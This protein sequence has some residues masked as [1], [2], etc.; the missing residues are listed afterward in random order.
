[1]EK[2]DIGQIYTEINEA[3]KS[4]DHEKV[5]SLSDKILKSDP[6]E[7]EA[8][9]TKLTAMT[10]LSR[11]DDIISI[12]EKGNQN[13]EYLLEYA[14]SLHEKKKYSESIAVLQ[15]YY[16][17]RADIKASINELLAQNYYKMGN[18]KESYKTYKEIV[19]AKISS[20]ELEEEKDLISNFLASY[21]LSET[22]DENMLNSMTK[23]LNSWE[24][25]YNYC[26]VCLQGGK[27]NETMETLARMKNEYSQIDDEFN[28]KKLVNLN[29]NLIQKSFEGFDLSKYSNILDE[30]EKFF[31]ENKH[32]ELFPY[33]YNNFIHIKKDK[34]SLNEILR[35]FDNIQ[36]TENLTNEEKNTLILNKIILLLRANRYNEALESYKNLQPSFTD[37]RYVIVYCYIYFKQEKIEKLDELVKND[38][39]LS[40]KPIAHLILIQLMLSTLNA[41]TIENFHFKVLN[42]INKFFEFSANYHFLSFFI[43]LYESRHLKDYIKEL[44]KNY[45]NINQLPLSKLNETNLKKLL[46]LLAK[47][48]YNVGMYEESANFYSYIIENVD[49]YDK[50]NKISLINSLAHTDVNKS[51]ELR[52][53]VDETMIDLSI[54]HINSLLNE[55]FLKFKKIQQD[56]TKKK[57]RKKVI[58]YPKNFDPKKPGPP[59]DPERW[60]PKLQR[61]KYRNVAKN[62]MAYQGATVDNVTTSSNFKK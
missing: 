14:Y 52:R 48:F 26:I 57:K 9:Q 39:E 24:S 46:H 11:N 58:K 28:E 54:D 21:I 40:T 61:K 47:T 10:N 50:E 2:I 34:E 16:S 59:P 33:F 36:K 13:K 56:K 32:S 15:K 1:M 23:Y 35:K 17:A 20:S 51:D 55:V 62:K 37:P 22:N 45:S 4:D 25:F 31:N 7:K 3:I 18:F 29:L 41:K 53:G 38:K 5:L 19:E 43:G 60:I 12:I 27:F 44:V 6:K 49:K 8:F 42:F 30:Y